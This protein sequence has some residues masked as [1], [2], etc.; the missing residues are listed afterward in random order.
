MAAPE[1]GPR[2]PLLPPPELDTPLCP[3]T[4]SKCHLPLSRPHRRVRQHAPRASACLASTRGA[5]DGAR[6]QGTAFCKG[7]A[8]AATGSPEPPRAQLP[9][10]RGAA[11]SDLV[12]D[13]VTRVRGTLTAGRPAPPVLRGDC[14]HSTRRPWCHSPRHPTKMLASPANADPQAVTPC[15]PWTP[16]CHQQG[17]RGPRRA[18]WPRALGA[19]AS[20]VPGQAG[21][22]PWRGR[23]PGACAGAAGPRSHTRRR[24]WIHAVPRFG[25][26]CSWKGVP[27]LRRGAGA[28][29]AGALQA[30]EPAPPG[31]DEK[32]GAEVTQSRGPRIRPP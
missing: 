26:L 13:A 9:T 1:R 19:W 16:G 2:P 12:A 23:A 32:P 6:G 31:G 29:G 17:D 11:V 14:G 21:R 7:M 30:A 10:R 3:H 22:L 27:R 20:S 18:G 24:W 4:F 8:R 25:T 5:P 28:S 15:V